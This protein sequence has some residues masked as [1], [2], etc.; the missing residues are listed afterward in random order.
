[1]IL[2]NIQADALYLATGDSTSTA[3]TTTDLNR[4]LNRWYHRAIGIAMKAMNWELNGTYATQDLQSGVREYALPS[5]L[6]KVEKVEA[7]IDGTNWRVPTP[8]DQRDDVLG[9]T[10]TNETG[11]TK[12]FTNNNPAYDLLDNSLFLYSGSIST[13]PG[14]LKVWYTAEAI[15][16][17][18]PT[19]EPNLLEQFQRYLAYGAAYDY[20]L[21]RD[22]RRTSSLRAEITNLENSIEDDYSSRLERRARLTTKRESF[23]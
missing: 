6:I 19:D 5:G 16:L 21:T 13:V 14:G 3:Y 20:A 17:A 11:I 23:R 4:N 15:E 10:I 8:V 1:M 9:A 22:L 2:S 12:I 7:E 18:N